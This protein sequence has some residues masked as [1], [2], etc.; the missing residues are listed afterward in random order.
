MGR[1]V[2]EVK[3]WNT[4]IIGAYVL[5]RFTKG[6]CSKHPTGEAPI[7]HLH[8]IA[9]AIVTSEIISA[10]ISRR[11]R[12]LEAF[13]RGFNDEKKMDILACLQQRIAAKKE[14]TFKSIDIAVSTGLLAWE[15]ESAKLYPV[16]LDEKSK[17]RKLGAAML[18]MG[19]KAEILGEWFAMHDVV[20]IAAYLGVI[21]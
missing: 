10:H 20:S 9:S 17:G 13:V 21:L 19:N 4:P 3:E 6:F 2:E 18:G 11:R 5:W 12:N 1:L 16:T 14:Y 15:Y 7:A 8:F